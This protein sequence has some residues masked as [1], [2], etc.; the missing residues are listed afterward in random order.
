[1]LRLLVADA[2]ERDHLE[3]G[4]D[5]ACVITAEGATIESTYNHTMT[6]TL[7]KIAYRALPMGFEDGM[8]VYDIACTVFHD[9]ASGYPLDITVRNTIASYLT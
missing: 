7:P 3:A 9:A 4:D 5:L 1:A 8:A 2:T 6:I